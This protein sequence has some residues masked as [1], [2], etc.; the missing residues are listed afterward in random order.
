M[1]ALILCSSSG[2]HIYPAI[3]FGNYLKSKGVDVEYLGFKNQMEENIIKNNIHLLDSLNSFSKIIKR[4]KSVFVL[5]KEIMRFKKNNHYDAYIGFGGFIS[6]LGI[7]LKGKE[8]YFIHEQNVILGDSNKIARL[9]SK[10]VFYSFS[11]TDRKGIL[12]G[13]PSS[14]KMEIKSFDYKSKLSILF[15]FGSLGSETLIKKL[16]EI[17][18][19]L[20]D[21]HK[22]T[23][24]L[25]YKLYEQY[26]MKFKKITIFKFINLKNE[27]KNYDLV[28]TRGGATTL[29]ELIYSRT[30]SI[31]IPSPYVK[32]NH[33]EKNVDYLVKKNLISKIKETDFNIINIK[34]EIDNYLNI[35]YCLNRYNSF[36]KEISFNSCELMFNEIV[37][38]VKN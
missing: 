35:D 19:Q 30:Y 18:D 12:V 3:S 24:V 38:Y 9:F 6:F 13:N 23:L 15:V 2:G 10:K 29:Y 7:F 5:V 27:I 28:F 4:P 11:N 33:Q 1:K 34:K 37:K 25:G 17:E 31:S 32:N 16:L 20:P 8:N 22:Y 21:M 26:H 14:H 36:K